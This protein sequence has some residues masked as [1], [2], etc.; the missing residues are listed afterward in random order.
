MPRRA[1]AGEKQ[2]YLQF[3]TIDP[4]SNRENSNLRR[5]VRSHAGGWV[6]RR[7]LE[8]QD[9][10]QADPGV[11]DEFEIETGLIVH[12]KTVQSRPRS[13]PKSDKPNHPI[14]GILSEASRDFV[15][16]PVQ[17]AGNGNPSMQLSSVSSEKL[18]PFQSYTSTSPLPNGLVSSSNKYCKS[19]SMT[20]T[21]SSANISSQVYRWYGLALCQGPHLSE[22]FL[23][24]ALKA[25]FQVL[26]AIQHFTVPCCTG[27]TPTAELCGYKN[28]RVSSV[29]MMKEKW[30]YVKRILSGE[31]T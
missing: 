19:S 22:V 28:D 12:E 10:L 2:Q 17:R 26:S 7:L 30:R 4:S 15:P 31:S 24:P 27:H 14:A 20:S 6:W 16:K 29:A 5:I 21:P 25:G 23:M 1:P 8:S 13:T 18:D 3:V 9:S 11:D